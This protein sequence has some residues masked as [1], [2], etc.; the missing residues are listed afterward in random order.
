[1]TELRTVRLLDYPIAEYLRSQEHGDE[2][3]REF[4]L[5]VQSDA[6][7]RDV[8]ERLLELVDLITEEYGGFSA[9]PEGERDAAAARGENFIDLLYEVP[10]QVREVCLT[11]DRMIDEIDEYCREGQLLTLATPPD[12]REFWRWS[13][14][15]FVRQIDGEPP[16]P[17]PEFAAR[18]S[19]A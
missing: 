1:M 6:A 10:A 14:Y 9:G 19:T 13:F 17:W 18:L 7:D 8:P 3:V 11:L 16:I 5:I 15:E 2:L 4:Y 12:I